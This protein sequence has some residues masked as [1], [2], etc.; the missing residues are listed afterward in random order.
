MIPRSSLL[1]PIDHGSPPGCN[2]AP[3]EK[4]SAVQSQASCQNLDE[5][6]RRAKIRVGSEQTGSESRAQINLL[7][8]SAENFAQG[9]AHFS[10]RSPNL[11]VPAENA[12]GVTPGEVLTSNARPSSAGDRCDNPEVTCRCLVVGGLV[13]LARASGPESRSHPTFPCQI[14]YD[15]RT[16]PSGTGPSR[17]YNAML[18]RSNFVDGNAGVP[19]VQSSTGTF[20]LAPTVPVARTLRPCDSDGHHPSMLAFTL[21]PTTPY[22]S[23]APPATPG[24]TSAPGGGG[25][26]CDG[27]GFPSDGFG[28]PS[29]PP[30]GPPRGGGGGPPPTMRP[31]GPSGHDTFQCER[32]TGTFPTHLRRLC[33]SCKFSCCNDCCRDPS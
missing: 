1:G 26:A 29:G 14:S 13:G 30:G 4:A 22:P 25:G 6:L 23:A 31:S 3:A 10:S 20:T 2:A 8:P 9:S 33:V 19:V 21:R 12:T 32:C 28:E 11:A 27:G 16:V 24:P 17:W 15:T 5:I 18:G 7:G